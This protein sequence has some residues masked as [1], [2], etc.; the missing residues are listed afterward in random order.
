M[1][2]F[3]LHLPEKATAF[4]DVAPE[5]ALVNNIVFYAKIMPDNS[6]KNHKGKLL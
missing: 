2:I 3:T 5:T 4:R 6:G 1:V